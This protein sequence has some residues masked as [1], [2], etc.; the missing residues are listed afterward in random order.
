MDIQAKGTTVHCET[1][2][3]GKQKILLLHGWGCDIS[4]MMPVAKLLSDAATCTIIDF[5]GHGKSGR[6]PEPWGVPEYAECLK[7][8]MEQLDL[9]GCS[10]IA[11]S[12]GGRVA[13][14]LA[15]HESDIFD[16]I[17]FTGAAGLRK[18]ST[19][20]A[21]G[22]TKRYKQLKKMV[23]VLGKIPFLK[24][25]ADGMQE[26][27]IQKYGSPDYRALDPE[28]RKTFVKVINQD[29]AECYPEIR[30]STLLVWGQNDTETPLWMGQ[31]MEK[32]IPDAGLVVLDG[33]HFAY[34]KHLQQF[35]V[36]VKKFL[37]EE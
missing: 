29:L 15:A 14:W 16:K 26:K 27:L 18:E 25:F 36:I 3:Q 19:G 33:D 21:S 11:H 7:A 17:V 22:K 10:V 5:P 24:G 31:K 6:P 20:K 12:F 8:V 9:K 4:L 34:L 13:A 2:G 1:V 37:T 35:S 28:M 30:S 32:L 23:S